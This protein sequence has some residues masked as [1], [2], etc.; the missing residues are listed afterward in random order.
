MPGNALALAVSAPGININNIWH[1][2]KTSDMALVYSAIATL[3]LEKPQYDP[4][5]IT[6]DMIDR[7][8]L[9]TTGDELKTES[10][11]YARL[12]CKQFVITCS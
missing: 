10:S 9:P 8:T 12:Q 1:I 5:F 6:L 4:V 11:E 2:E 3:L 7:W